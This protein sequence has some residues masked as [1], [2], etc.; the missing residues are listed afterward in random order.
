MTSEEGEDGGFDSAGGL[1]DELNENELNE[2]KKLLHG[3]TEFSNANNSDCIIDNH[4][5]RTVDWVDRIDNEI[6]VY[7]DNDDDEDFDPE[8]AGEGGN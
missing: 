3:N 8:T 5:T 7:N 1:G 4:I 2:S 6:S